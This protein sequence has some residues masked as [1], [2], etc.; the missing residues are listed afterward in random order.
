MFCYTFK[1]ACYVGHCQFNSAHLS[2]NVL[3]VSRS[4]KPPFVNLFRRNSSCFSLVNRISVFGFI[5]INI[6]SLLTYFLVYSTFFSR[7]TS[8]FLHLSSVKKSPSIH[9]QTGF[10]L[11]VS[12]S[13]LVLL[14]SCY[15]FGRLRKS[16]RELYFHSHAQYYF[17]PHIFI[18]LSEQLLNW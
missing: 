11:L 5:F 15:A 18:N 8:L 10:S 6:S 2:F 12:N 1:Q 9:C 4:Q 7:Y 17:I 14:I 3:W 16:A 13:T